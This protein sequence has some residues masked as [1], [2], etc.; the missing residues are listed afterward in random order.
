MVNVWV[1][2]LDFIFLRRHMGYVIQKIL[3][4]QVT[5]R[6]RIVKVVLQLIICLKENVYF[7]LL[8]WIHFVI[9]TKMDFV[10]LVSKITFYGM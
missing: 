5:M 4:V 10:H 2:N 7:Q 9:H 1:V 3:L 6:I 8:G